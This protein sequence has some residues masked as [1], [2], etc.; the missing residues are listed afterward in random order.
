MQSNLPPAKRPVASERARAAVPAGYDRAAS[1]MALQP[2]LQQF[3]VDLHDVLAESGLPPEMFDHP[4]NLVPFRDGSRLLGLCVDRTGCAHLGLLI[5]EHTQLEALG[6]LAD[7]AKAAPDVRSA[8]CLLVRYLKLSDGGGLCAL[9]EDARFANFSYA[10]YEPGVE[11]AEV[12]YDISIATLWNVMRALC[13]EQWLPQEILLT[14]RHPA[15]T[16]P[17]RSF[18]RA[19]LRFDCDECALIFDKKWLDVPLPGADPRRLKALEAQ[20]RAI[21][22]RSTSEFPARVRQVVRRQLLS[23]RSSMHRVAAELAMH[24]RTL[25]RQLKRHGLNFK[26]LGDELRFEI[27]RQLLSTTTMPVAEVAYSLHY[28]NAGAFSTAFRRWAGCAPSQWRSTART[29]ATTAADA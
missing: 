9:R 2:L 24:R 17:Y 5:G 11:R 21:E 29:Q 8:L 4:D 28:A 19:P 22:A 12:V 13:G 26:V 25:D 6:L 3:G 14:R 16:R 7:L 27:A 1:S 18:L 23:G 15:D 10:L 20:A